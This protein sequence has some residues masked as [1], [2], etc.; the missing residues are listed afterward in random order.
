MFIVPCVVKL[1]MIDRYVYIFFH[2]YSASV[3][4]EN[5]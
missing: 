1:I 5:M 3:T 4:K 2:S